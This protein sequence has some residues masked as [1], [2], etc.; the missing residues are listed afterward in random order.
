MKFFLGKSKK[1][2]RQEERIVNCS[3]I[4][5]AKTIVYSS[6]LDPHG[7]GPLTL[8]KYFLVTEKDGKY[9]ELLSGVELKKESDIHSNGFA[10]SFKNT[11]Y[12]ENITPLVQYLR[13]E[14]LKTLL[15]TLSYENLFDS[16]TTINVELIL[17]SKKE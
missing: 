17:S 15:K 6:F 1:R 8:E 2:N 4:F 12:I 3:E 16:I 10:V 14:T 11:P 13:D 7:G 5:V 9:F